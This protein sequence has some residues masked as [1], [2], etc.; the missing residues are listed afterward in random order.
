MS[1]CSHGENEPAISRLARWMKFN[2]VGGIGIGVQFLSLYLLKSVFHF[3]YLVATVLAVET[4]VMHNFIWHERYTWADR[5]QFSWRNSLPRLIRF[6]LGNGAVSIL[7]NLVLMKVM[8]GLGH[9]NYLVA[10]AIAIVLCSVANFLVSEE[11]VFGKH[12]SIRRLKLGQSRMRFAGTAES[13]P[14]PAQ[15]LGA[16]VQRLPATISKSVNTTSPP[17][18]S[19]V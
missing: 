4:A 17:A 16:L 12:S 18:N 1:S 7:G 3:N 19:G 11:W 15:M 2:L 14:L 13:R 5:V 6:H 8:A 9:V 10:N